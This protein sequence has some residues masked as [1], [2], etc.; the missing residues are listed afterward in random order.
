MPVRERK[1]SVLKKSAQGAAFD[2]AYAVLNPEQRRAVDTVEGPVMVVAGPGTGKTQVLA[3]RVA[4]ILKRTQARPSN[5][6]CLTFSVSGATAMR[7]RLRRL[8]GSDAYGVTVATVHGYCQSLIDAHPVLFEDW[9]ARSM[10]TDIEKIKEMNKI[11][12][13]NFSLCELINPKDPFGKSSEILSRISQVKRE[14]KTL[15]DLRRVEG[16]YDAAMSG[17]SRDGTKAHAANM[18]SAKKF[19]DFTGIFAAYEE[20]LRGSGR[21]DYDDMILF[22]LAA[23]TRDEGLLAGQQVRYQYILVDEAQD[24]NGAQWAVIERLTTAVDVPQDPNIFL[25]GDD[26]QAI[27]RFQGANLTHMLAFH[28]RF[29]QAPV[30]VL[31]TSYRSTQKILDAATRLIDKNDERLI[32]KIPGLAKRLRASTGE[33]GVE[34]MLL[35]SPS[36]AAEPWLIADLVEERI[37]SGVAPKEIAVLTQTNAE[38]R[39]LFDVLRA[40]KIPV[41]LHGKADLLQHALVLQALAMLR[42]VE[43]PRSDALLLSALACDCLRCHPADVARVAGM[44]RRDKR[45]AMDVLQDIEANAAQFYDVPTLVRARDLLLDLHGKIDSRTVLETVENAMT[46][47]GLTQQAVDGKNPLDLA[48]IEAFFGWVKQLCLDR[49]ALTFRAFLA[50]LEYYADPAYGDIRLTYALPHLVTDGV[51]LITAHQSKGLE[52]ETVILANFR[53]GHWDKRR[54]P[55]LIA[56]PEDLLFGWEKEQKEFEKHQDER[57]VAYVAMTRAKRELIAVCPREMSIGAKNRPVSPSAFFAE[58]GPLPEQDRA[59]ADPERASLLLLKPPRVIDAEMAAY[60]RSRLESFALS[61]TSLNRFLEAP[62]EFLRVDLLEQP[63][64][65]D[66][67][68]IRRIGYGSAAHWALRTWAI[69][70]QASEPIAVE[71]FL[72]AYEWHLQERSILTASQRRDLTALGRASLARYYEERLAGHTPFIHTVEREY[73][74][75]LL[76][77]GGNDIPIKGKIDRIDLASADSATA[78]VIDYKTGAPKSQEKLAGSNEERQLVFYAILLERA[79]AM[80]KPQSF[81]LDFLGGERDEPVQ[82]AI[83][84]THA[85]K[86]ELRRVIGSV[87]RKILALDFNPL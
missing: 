27:Y 39:T 7:E 18:R 64:H 17:K 62:Q 20:M 73:R 75:H 15:D 14:G 50:E 26:D 9:S 60:I 63:E 44:A 86:E 21:Y 65:F 66:E 72:A 71:K 70:I 5:I 40:R 2:E 6:L 24:L 43:H 32:G 87:W 22:V 37:A 52:F 12:E 55:S 34:P 84:V 54:A 48:A 74:A 10:I 16:E 46:G 51:Q 58:A 4:N 69:G 31:E 3:V 30:I 19:R 77:D 49:P 53:D 83:Q 35:R 79:E 36:D 13:Q 23:L 25:V 81:V 11:I 8:I 45:H 28:R 57:R 1:A 29:P 33:K 59:L 38:L 85:Q 47:G 82:R 41:I 76:E 56:L 42:G 67:G 78:T 61:P 80:L 68:T